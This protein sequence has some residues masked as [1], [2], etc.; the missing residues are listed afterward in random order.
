[1]ENGQMTDKKEKITS[2][3]KIQLCIQAAV[4]KKAKN[5][6]VLD[7]SELSSF[8]DYF[9][10]SSGRSDRQVQG[11]AGSIEKSLKENGVYP[12]G[13]EGFREG[14]WV[15]IDYGDVIIHVFYEPT[16]AFYSLEKIWKG[17]A[18]IDIG[19]FIKATDE[20]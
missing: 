8:A 20:L 5:L 11:I 16:R 17:A 14:K 9:I 6:L 13:V 2:E 1:M 7:I 12:L 10:I 18:R 19:R 15:L 4:D 3:K